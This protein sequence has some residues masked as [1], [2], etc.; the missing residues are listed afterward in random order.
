MKGGRG[1]AI[2]KDPLVVSIL[3]KI[4]QVY[5]VEISLSAIIII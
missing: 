1:G 2:K 4:V 5:E 3:L